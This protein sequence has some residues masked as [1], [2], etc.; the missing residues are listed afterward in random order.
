MSIAVPK[1]GLKTGVPGFERPTTADVEA[2]N[3]PI[4]WFAGL[5]AVIIGLVIYMWTDWLA[6]GDAKPVPKGDTPTPLW[7]K[8]C[9]HGLEGIAL[10]IVAWAAYGWVWKP[11]KRER[12]LSTD[13]L[14]MG[15]WLIT[16]MLADPWEN[17]TGITYSY[18]ANFINLGCPQCHMLGWNSPNPNHMG[19]PLLF[20]GG[21]YPGMLFLGTVFSC[22][23]MRKVK[24]RRPQTAAMGL[25][26]VAVLSMFIW[27]FA[28][29]IP[30]IMAGGWV[31]W[32]GGGST[33][34]FSGHYF[35]QP[36]LEAITW[37]ACWGVMGCVRY[38]KNDKGETIF[39][40]GADRL[41]MGAKGVMGVRFLALTGGLSTMMVLGYFLPYQFYATHAHATPPSICSKSYFTT[42]LAGP[43]TD[44]ACPT[45]NTPIPLRV[46]AARI[47]PNGTLVVP[48][49]TLLPV[50]PPSDTK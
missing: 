50:D 37:G 36:M 19:E 44:Y 48:T 8:I 42:G 5:G 41:R 13:A 7:M 31:W 49:G 23:A 38:F 1:P 20:I 22:W 15:A 4:K 2:R 29:E 30:P 34:L 18:N 47:G 35:Q 33:S 45:P 28:L 26:G 39:E 16:Y 10:L 32:W 9:I 46:R 21:M 3:T 24:A 6:D 14:M 25:V 43:G 12:R 27:D 11:W 40:R 17:Y